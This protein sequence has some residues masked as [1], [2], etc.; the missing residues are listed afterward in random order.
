MRSIYWV[1]NAPEAKHVIGTL[2]G[3]ES[4]RRKNNLIVINKIQL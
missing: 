4:I 1:W 2:F 3:G